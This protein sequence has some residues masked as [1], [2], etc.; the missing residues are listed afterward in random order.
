[1]AGNYYGATVSASP[2]TADG[3]GIDEGRDKAR[4]IPQARG[5]VVAD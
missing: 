3:I 1:M 5:G 4:T 2:P